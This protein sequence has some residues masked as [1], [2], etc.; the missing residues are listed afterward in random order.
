M[1]KEILSEKRGNLW[2]EKFEG[3]KNKAEIENGNQ[4]IAWVFLL[5]E[6]SS[7]Y[8]E[9]PHKVFYLE[10]ED[11]EK[12]APSLPHVHIRVVNK[13][14]E[15]YSQV[16]VSVRSNDTMIFED[17]GLSAALAA[18]LEIYF[19]FNL[20]YDSEGDTTLNLIQRILGMKIF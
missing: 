17:I 18:T 13:P 11:G 20:C 8:N 10:G 7:L 19:V 2:E 16:L 14:C 4:T 15:D 12:E 1:V 9:K 5:R 3:I 6:W